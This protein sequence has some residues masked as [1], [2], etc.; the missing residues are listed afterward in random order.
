[1][2]PI[3]TTSISLLLFNLAFTWGQNIHARDPTVDPYASIISEADALL[4][5]L[6]ANPIDLGSIATQINSIQ[7]GLTQF[8]LT[9]TSFVPAYT[10]FSK[11][12][13]PGGSRYSGPYVSDIVSSFSEY[14][15]T[16]TVSPSSSSSSSGGSV[17]SLKIS[18]SS[19]SESSAL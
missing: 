7:S 1:M 15:K 9:V 16:K 10:D 4:S 3:C 11:T 2:L 12:A 17:S 18:S 6:D 8:G 14:Q 13:Q 19:I 5:S